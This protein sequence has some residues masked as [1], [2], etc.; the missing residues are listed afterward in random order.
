MFMIFGTSVLIHILNW[1]ALAS[2]TPNFGSILLFL[3]FGLPLLASIMK[4]EY[5]FNTYVPMLVSYAGMMAIGV[6]KTLKYG[7][8][9][10]SKE[11]FIIYQSQ[12]DKTLIKNQE[13][14]FQR[15][16][17][18][19]GS[20][21]LGILFS[22]STLSIVSKKIMILFCVCATI[23]LIFW[24]S[25]VIWLSKFLQNQIKQSTQDQQNI[26]NNSTDTSIK[27]QQNNKNNS[28]PKSLETDENNI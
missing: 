22:V 20:I 7:A 6:F 23:T 13:A 18:S 15:M 25:I 1:Q 3:I 28:N 9:D 26:N 2:L 4:T 16:G 5:L 21:I 17:K 8:F 12:E 19:G 11:Q 14:L 27:F 10:T 24:H